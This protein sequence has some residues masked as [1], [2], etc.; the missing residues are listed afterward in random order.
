MARFIVMPIEGF[1]KDP[2]GGHLIADGFY[3]YRTLSSMYEI[4]LTTTQSNRTW[5]RDWLAMEGIF[6]YA[7][8][9]YPDYRVLITDTEGTGISRHL[10]LQGYDI[11]LWI[12]NDAELARDLITAGESIMLIVRPQYA[13]PEWHPDTPKG[14]PKWDDLVKKTLLD[15]AAKLADNRT[16]I[17]DL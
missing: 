17:E 11:D 16:E 6:K 10:R 13:I 7:Q 12:C 15:K 4:I 5:T 2:V 8:I 9:V 1:L 3:L 14:G